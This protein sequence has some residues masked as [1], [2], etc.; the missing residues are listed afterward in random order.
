MVSDIT[1]SIHYIKLITIKSQGANPAPPL[2]TVLGN[3]GVNTSNFCSEFN[4][5]TKTLPTYFMLR[6]TINIFDNRSYQFSIKLPSI[7]HILNLLKFERIIKVKIYDRINDKSIICV[8]LYQI[9]QLIQFKFGYIN[10]DN[11]LMIKGQ[12]NS[13][14]LI[15]VKE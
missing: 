5:Y 11:V 14:N 7:G 3:I 2:G 8:K 9:I 6:T 4:D 12:L 10:Y 13:M 15:V 1:R